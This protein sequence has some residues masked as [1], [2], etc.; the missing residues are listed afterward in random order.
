[1]TQEDRRKLSQI[2]LDREARLI[3]VRK[4]IKEES[5]IMQKNEE[6]AKKYNEAFRNRNAHIKELEQL[7]DDLVECERVEKEGACYLIMEGKQTVNGVKAFK[8]T[9]VMGQR[10]KNGGWATCL[11]VMNRADTSGFTDDNSD[12]HLMPFHLWK[13]VFPGFM[14]E[15][16]EKVIDRYREISEEEFIKIMEED[17]SNAYG[18]VPPES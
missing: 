6:A 3:E 18:T 10:G 11:C 14:K 15:D 8:I 2:R 16:G 13:P 1:M 12:I 7:E 9:R 5:G 17:V 4:A